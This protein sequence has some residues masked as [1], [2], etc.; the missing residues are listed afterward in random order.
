MNLDPIAFF[1]QPFPGD[2]QTFRIIILLFVMAASFF[3]TRNMRVRWNGIW[4]NAH[5]IRRVAMWQT[6]LLVINGVLLLTAAQRDDPIRVGT[7]C[8]GV[9]F[10]GLSTALFIKR[11]TR[12]FP[13]PRLL[14]S[15]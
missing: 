5:D 9:V 1:N 10:I 8:L 13:D 2:P 3:W 7:A 14:F 12:I 11:P 15:R 6:A 4:R